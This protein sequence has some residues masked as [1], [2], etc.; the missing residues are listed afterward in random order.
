[1]NNALAC[2]L[3]FVPYSEHSFLGEESEKKRYFEDK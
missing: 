2:R 1:M 3:F